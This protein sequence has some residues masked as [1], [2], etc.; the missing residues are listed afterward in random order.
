MTTMNKQKTKT[1]K[2]PLISIHAAWLDHLG[3]TAS[4]ACA[5]HCAVL[6]FVISMLPLWGIGFLANDWV[7][8][9]MIILS[10]IIG[11]YSLASS[12]PKHSKLLPIFVLVAGFTFIAAGHYFFEHL[13]ATLIPLGGLAIAAAHFINW[14]YSRRC[15]RHG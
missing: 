8:L 4:L 5:I 11:I 14:R 6:P 10:L 15:T 9:S 1:P 7:E 3:M 13:E 12:Y 2:R